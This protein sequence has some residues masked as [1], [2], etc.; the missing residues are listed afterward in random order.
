MTTLNMTRIWEIASERAVI[1]SERESK[2]RKGLKWKNEIV[3]KGVKKYAQEFLEIAFR[4]AKDEADELEKEISEEN[5]KLEMV[6]KKSGS[7]G[8]YIELESIA[9]KDDLNHG[10]SWVCDGYAID[11]YSLNPSWEG[12][13]ICYVYA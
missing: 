13:Y 11:K 2:V 5:K 8:R 9:E 6:A 7:N 1:A 3:N 4:D 10:V 12:D